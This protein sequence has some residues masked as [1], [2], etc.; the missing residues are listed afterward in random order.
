M[1][2]KRKNPFMKPGM[3]MKKAVKEMLEDAH[4]KGQTVVQKVWGKTEQSVLDHLVAVQANI[5]I[6]LRGNTLDSLV[7]RVRDCFVGPG[8]GNPV[9]DQGA[10]SDMCFDRRKEEQKGSGKATK[11][12]LNTD[13]LLGRLNGLKTERE[14]LGQRTR[15]LWAPSTLSSYPVS[16]YVTAYQG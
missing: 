7:C 4:R 3:S 14:R 6:L 11:A 5:V 2:N 9:D 10:K 13:G 8:A 12:R 1:I 15:G 16:Y